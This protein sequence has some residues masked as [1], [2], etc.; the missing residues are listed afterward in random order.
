MAP[1]KLWKGSQCQ[2]HLGS[3][4]AGLHGLR[5][6]SGLTPWCETRAGGRKG[7]LDGPCLAAQPRQCL[8]S[9]K[10]GPEC[11]EL[12]CHS[13]EAGGSMSS[14]CQLL[15]QSQTQLS[16]F[17][18]GQI[19]GHGFSVQHKV[20]DRLSPASPDHIHPAAAMP[21]WQKV[22]CLQGREGEHRSP[23]D[24]VLRVP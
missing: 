15:G 7:P 1:Q 20:W 6:V 17:V 4:P 24:P 23:T 18:K 10:R 9:Y 22:S 14:S 19:P 3:F 21:R 13:G 2:H 12:N 16:Q 11:A 5:E 8:L